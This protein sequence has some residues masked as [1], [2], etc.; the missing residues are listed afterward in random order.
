MHPFKLYKGAQILEV[1]ETDVLVEYGQL[2]DAL[3]YCAELMSLILRPYI[4]V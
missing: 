4:A 1:A 3:E 2:F